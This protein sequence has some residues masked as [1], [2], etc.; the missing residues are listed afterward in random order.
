M[1]ECEKHYQVGNI[2][3][4]KREPPKARR[5]GFFLDSEHIIQ[6]P[7]EKHLNTPMAIW[8]LTKQ[9]ELKSLQFFYWSWTGKTKENKRVRKFH[10]ENNSGRKRLF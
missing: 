7:P 5:Y 8:L 3:R 10:K 2:I 9:G 4:I 6:E 1:K